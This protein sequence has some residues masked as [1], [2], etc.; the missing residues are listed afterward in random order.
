MRIAY[1]LPRRAMAAGEDP[2]EYVANVTGHLARAGHQVALVG[3]LTAG[4]AAHV[5]AGVTLA[6]VVPQD[7]GRRYFTV[8]HAYSD[9]VLAA[10]QALA[11]AERLDAVEFVG[12]NGIAG[13]TPIRAKR[14]LVDLA[15][16]RLVVRLCGRRP[17][18][19]GSEL[20]T[21]FE[22]A[23]RLYM[24]SY[25][26]RFADAAVAATRSIAASGAAGGG[27]PAWCI[28]PP[29]AGSTLREGTAD[30]DARRV[31]FGAPLHPWNGFDLFVRAAR[32]VLREDPSFVFEVRG[33]DTDSD[34][35]GGSFREHVLRGLDPADADRLVF[36]AAPAAERAGERSDAVHGRPPEAAAGSLWVLPGRWD[37]VPHALLEAMVRGCVPV[38]SDLPGLRELVAGGRG[39]AADPCTPER[40]AEVLLGLV[41]EPGRLEALS[42]AASADMRRRCDPDGVVRLL[43][44]CYAGRRKARPVPAS[45]ASVSEE[46]RVS[47]V[48]PFRDQGRYVEQAVA[49]VRASSYRNIEIVVVDDGS[50]DPAST[51]VFR[52]LEVDTKLSQPNRGL[53]AARNRGI[54]ASTGA[55]VLPLDADDLIHERY[56][57]T[58]VAAL[59]RHPDL[60]YVSCYTR[61]F[62]LFDGAFVPVGPV[63][64]VMLYLQTF[65]SCANVYR[66]RALEQVGGYD[67]RMIAYENWDLLVTMAERGLAGD[68]LPLEL[69]WYRR[70]ADS[71]VFTLSDLK[72]AELI[73]YMV[74]KH[75]QVLA[76]RYLTVVLNLVHLWKQGHELDGS[77][78][79]MRS[80]P[81][82]GPPGDAC[83]P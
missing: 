68:V 66:K 22:D 29:L 57:E 28:P 59:A 39:I 60:A 23:I 44:R 40:L 27:A 67:E 2:W 71:M 16:T 15:A 81:A 55:L 11:R 77:V 18:Q 8:D 48:I 54:A 10:L 38:V 51:A 75:S 58:A 53:A 20:P 80:S 43:E 33:P 70:H 73:Q 41:Q 31:V 6:P 14:L 47:V 5:P 56:I 62:G 4:Q 61:D 21:S 24:E 45:A 9:S 37:H 32:L 35:F 1:V 34:P 83:P 74:R 30:V 49:S 19:H 82:A 63:P 69:F 46:P 3:E 79:F 12:D 13:F 52:A 26:L 76:D 65:G 36:T 7:S 72:R 78:L 64:D 42:A 17:R 25:C 50:V